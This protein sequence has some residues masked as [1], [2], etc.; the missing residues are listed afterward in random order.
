VLNPGSTVEV[1][2]DGSG[3]LENRFEASLAGAAERPDR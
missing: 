3:T 1:P 2:L